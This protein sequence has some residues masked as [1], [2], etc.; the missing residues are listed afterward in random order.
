MLCLPSSVAK[1]GMK[2]GRA[3]SINGLLTCWLRRNDDLR[4]VFPRTELE[5]GVLGGVGSAALAMNA[6]A[7]VSID[8]FA[9]VG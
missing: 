3:S 2:G 1:S 6:S 9:A 5:G 8:G 7:N 4:G